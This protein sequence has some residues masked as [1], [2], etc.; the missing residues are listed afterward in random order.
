ML[1][2]FCKRPK[3]PEKI[4]ALCFITSFNKI[5][6][7]SV[8]PLWQDSVQIARYININLW[9]IPTYEQSLINN[10]NKS[11]EL[12]KQVQS[13]TRRGEDKF[14]LFKDTS[15]V[16]IFYDSLNSK[17]G[18]FASKDSLME[19]YAISAIK[20]YDKATDTIY[21]DIYYASTHTG[22]KVIV[23]K[24]KTDSSI[25]DSTYI[26]YAEGHQTTPFDVED[27]LT[28]NTGLKAY[29]IRSVFNSTNVTINH[30]ISQSKVECLFEIR[31]MPDVEAE[32]FSV[33]FDRYK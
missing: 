28:M 29:K 32:R 30:T 21:S 17:S 27:E 5:T 31:I 3:K 22:V 8:L 2:F 11:G 15:Q 18:N 23:P 14:F 20:F 33:F 9:V 19:L 12:A 16:A 7:D 6:G 4:G 10:F 26:Y 13:N 1:G 24:H 25:P